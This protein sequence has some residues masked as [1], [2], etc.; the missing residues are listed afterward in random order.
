MNSCGAERAAGD[1]TELAPT[2]E[3]YHIEA[4]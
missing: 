3:G 4:Q 2:L 1:A